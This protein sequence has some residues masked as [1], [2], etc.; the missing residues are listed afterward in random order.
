MY[1]NPCSKQYGTSD[2]VQTFFLMTEN[3]NI[4]D[5]TPEMEVPQAPVAVD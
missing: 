1:N 2:Q 4:I 5:E 3:E